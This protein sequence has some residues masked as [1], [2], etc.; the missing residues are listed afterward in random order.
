MRNWKSVHSRR[1]ETVIIYN[2]LVFMKLSIMPQLTSKILAIFALVT[3]F[4]NILWFTSSLPSSFDFPGPLGRPSVLPEAWLNPF[5]Y[6]LILNH[7]LVPPTMKR[8]LPLPL[9]S[10][11]CCFESG[12]RTFLLPANYSFSIG[13]TYHVKNAHF[14]HNWTGTIRKTTSLW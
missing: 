7:A 3:P 14:E 1:S 12:G 13:E 9:M 11:L 6:I 5:L 2:P 4:L 10:Y 8:L